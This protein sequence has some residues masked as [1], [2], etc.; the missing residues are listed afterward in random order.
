MYS[1]GDREE[2][3]RAFTRLGFQP[4]PAAMMLH[5][6]LA[7]RQSNAC[8]RTFATGFNPLKNS[9]DALEMQRFD[10]DAIVF[11]MELP[12]RHLQCCSDM[13]LQWSIA[14]KFNGIANEVLK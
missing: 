12:H 11:Y 8:A 6:L 2:K 7:V 1:F 4:N 10:T 14:G 5:N 13:N 3:G 9:K